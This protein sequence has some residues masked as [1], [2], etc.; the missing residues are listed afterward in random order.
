M[1][2]LLQILNVTMIRIL[3]KPYFISVLQMGILEAFRRQRG[4]ITKVQFVFILFMGATTTL[5]TIMNSILAHQA[6]KQAARRLSY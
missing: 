2:R 5:P 1:V 3:K 6:I 4:K